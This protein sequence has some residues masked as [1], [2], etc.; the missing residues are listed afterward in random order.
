MIEERHVQKPFELTH[1]QVYASVY[2]EELPERKDVFNMEVSAFYDLYQVGHRGRSIRLFLTYKQATK[3]FHNTGFRMIHVSTGK[4]PDANVTIEALIPVLGKEL[5]G[6]ATVNAIRYTPQE[7]NKYEHKVVGVVNHLLESDSW[8]I[9][10]Q[11][12]CRISPSK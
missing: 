7:Y 10:G 3:P 4:N 9:N 2:E 1:G 8:F 12:I 6:T 11:V 5:Q